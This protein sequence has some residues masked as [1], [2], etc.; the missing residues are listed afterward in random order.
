MAKDLRNHGESPHAEPHDYT[1]MAEDVAEFIRHHKLRNPTVIGHSMCVFLVVPGQPPSSVWTG[2]LCDH[3]HLRGAKTAMTMALRS[4][5]LV[6]NL[7]SVDNA[8]V[9]S[10]LSPDFARYV[11]GMIKVEESNCTSQKEADEILQSYESVRH[12]CILRLLIITPLT[13]HVS[14]RSRCPYGSSS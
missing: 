1:H 7:V 14:S 4:P 10:E 12:F 6:A 8:P 2:H 11:E 13:W 9:R 3:D 5:E